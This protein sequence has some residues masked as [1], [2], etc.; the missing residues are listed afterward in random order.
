MYEK[1]LGLIHKNDELNDIMLTIPEMER[2]LSKL[3]GEVDNNPEIRDILS[4]I[5]KAKTHRHAELVFNTL[6]GAISFKL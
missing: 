6:L 5:Q 4:T 3:E 2:Q 1:L